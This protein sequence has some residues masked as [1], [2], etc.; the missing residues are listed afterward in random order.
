MANKNL[1][2]AILTTSCGIT[3]N[4]FVVKQY[5]ATVTIHV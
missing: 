1:N 4:I 3:A 5:Y 2:K